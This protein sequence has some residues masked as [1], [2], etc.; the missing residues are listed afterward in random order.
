MISCARKTRIHFD[1]CLLQTEEKVGINF[2]RD[3]KVTEKT[4]SNAKK[5]R[6]PWKWST[7]KKRLTT[8]S[9]TESGKSSS[10]GEESTR[11]IPVRQTLE[12]T[13]S[14][15]ERIRSRRAGR[16]ESVGA[17]AIHQIEL[18]MIDQG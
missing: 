7:M 15:A 8:W 12:T 4:A 10:K 16:R 6:R 9:M 2:T 14:W 11:T 3:T 18:M 13:R 5:V 1:L 17:L